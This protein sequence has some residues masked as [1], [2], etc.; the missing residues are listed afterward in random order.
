MG[1][2]DKKRS[3]IIAFNSVGNDGWYEAVVNNMV[4]KATEETLLSQ[5][6]VI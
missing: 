3:S 2:F 6:I 4:H 5:F 1:L